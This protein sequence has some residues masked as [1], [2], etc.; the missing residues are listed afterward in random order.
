MSR[1]LGRRSMVASGVTDESEDRLDGAGE[2][3]QPRRERRIVAPVRAADVGPTDVAGDGGGERRQGEGLARRRRRATVAPGPTR[4]R[5]RGRSTA[6]RRPRR[7]NAHS[8]RSVHEPP[9]APRPV[10]SGVAIARR[11]APTGS[12]VARERFEAV[13]DAQLVDHRRERLDG[14]PQRAGRVVGQ[15]GERVE[16]RAGV[17]DRRRVRLGNSARRPAQTSAS[18][19]MQISSL[20]TSAAG[21]VVADRARR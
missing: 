9:R 6:R 17:L 18:S 7:C 21:W 8:G 3:A 16:R 14:D 1:A 19:V 13:G 12:V 4:P 5:R 10:R 11:E 20:A 15:D 2:P